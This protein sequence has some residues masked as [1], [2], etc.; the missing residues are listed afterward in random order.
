MWG[1]RAVSNGRLALA[2]RKTRSS[3]AALVAVL[4]GTTSAVATIAGI[5]IWVPIAAA[6]AATLG[7]LRVLQTELL[8]PFR[9]E[10]VQRATV[11]VVVMKPDGH[12]EAGT[13]VHL[14]DH[15]WLTAAHLCPKGWTVFLRM[16]GEDVNGTVFQMVESVD[17]A[18]VTVD[19]DWPW[20]GIAARADPDTGDG[21]KVVGWT[22][23]T[24]GR[25]GRLISLDFAVDGF[26]EDSTIVLRGS[27][28][29]RGFSGAPVVELRTGRV[30]GVVSSRSEGEFE[31]LNE[32]YVGPVSRIQSK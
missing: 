7:G 29:P 8:V 20:R 32:T 21:V 9:L 16:L 6:I 2:V 28:P 18:I 27:F 11:K 31:H 23:G 14:G 13:A 24:R 5:T 12:R 26:A 15:R 4:G 3:W 10:T 25:K 22:V 17:L 19:R 30:I 1:G